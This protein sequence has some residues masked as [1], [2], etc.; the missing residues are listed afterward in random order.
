MTIIRIKARINPT[1][2]S[3]KVAQAVYNLLGN[4]KVEINDDKKMLKAEINQINLLELK[5]KIAQDRIRNTLY[6]VFT[7]WKK[8]DSLSFG[9]NRQAAYAGHVSL[10]LENEDPMGPIHF[11]IKGN[12]DEVIKFLCEK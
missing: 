12:I 10:N 4:I 5:K 11:E 9:L 1:E 3:K 8:Q 7:R 2:D 6:S